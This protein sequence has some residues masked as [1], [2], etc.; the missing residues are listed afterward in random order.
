MDP[1]W[2]GRM[3]NIEENCRSLHKTPQSCRKTVTIIPCVP[4]KLRPLIIIISSST[5]IAVSWN[6][7]CVCGLSL[8]RCWQFFIV[9]RQKL[10]VWKAF[11]WEKKDAYNL[12]SV[13][14]FLARKVSK[15]KFFALGWWRIISISSKA[16]HTHGKISGR[17]N[18]CGECN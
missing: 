14:F 15:Q 8:C 3:K 18:F 11:L 5:Q 17:C 6:F 10:F 12:A 16:S 1:R 4:H 7:S 9:L 2:M 13:F